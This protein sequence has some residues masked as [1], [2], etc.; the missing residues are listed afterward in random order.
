MRDV[1]VI[2]P[3]VCCY[4]SRGERCCS[5][6]DWLDYAFNRVQVVPGCSL[7]AS[8]ARRMVG[9]V[10]RCDLCNL[11]CRF[12]LDDYAILPFAHD[13]RLYLIPVCSLAIL[14][15]PRLYMRQ[16]SFVCLVYTQ[17]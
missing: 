13:R 16:M 11:F 10:E 7:L 9:R 8:V 17:S 14:F 2:V 12:F 6:A 3:V 4:L 15:W 1:L 5:C